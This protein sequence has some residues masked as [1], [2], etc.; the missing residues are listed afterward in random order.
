MLQVLEYLMTLCKKKSSLSAYQGISYCSIYRV[1]IKRI[2][3]FASK[4]ECYTLLTNI[5]PIHIGVCSLPLIFQSVS[6]LTINTSSNEDRL[7]MLF[8][9]TNTSLMLFFITNTSF[10]FLFFTLTPSFFYIFR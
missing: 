9:I 4:I 8:F 5:L 3:W 10:F 6:E 7:L 2:S 1:L